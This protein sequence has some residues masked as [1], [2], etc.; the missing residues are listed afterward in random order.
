M[1]FPKINLQPGEIC[2]C[3]GQK[4]RGNYTRK[5]SAAD[6]SRE[7]GKKYGGR[8]VNPNSKRQIALRKKAEKEAKGGI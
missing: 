2:P 4:K 6:A 8:P 1:E 5:E 7:N 3:C